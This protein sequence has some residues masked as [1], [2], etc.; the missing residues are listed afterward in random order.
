MTARYDIAIVGAGMAG[1]SLAA[2]LGGRASVLLIEAE[3]HPGYHATGRSAAFWHEG[4]GGPLL[5]PLSRASHPL[6]EAGG[7]ETLSAKRILIAT[8]ARPHVPSCPGHEHGITSNE[9][10][11]LDAIPAPRSSEHARAAFRPPALQPVVRDFAFQVPDDLAADA[12]VRAVRSADKLLIS[13][14]R[15]FDRYEGEQLL[16]LA[17]EVVLQP[18]DKSLTEGEIAEVSSKIVAAAQKLGAR[19]RG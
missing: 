12:L 1:A 9:A 11:H 17:V 6:L 16:S 7:E 14:A 15:L 4:Y 5:A 19:L 13:D 8:G 18:G 3:A 2:A 10:F